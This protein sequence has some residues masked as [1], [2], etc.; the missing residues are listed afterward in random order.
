MTLVGNLP[1]SFQIVSIAGDGGSAFVT[2][3]DKGALGVMAG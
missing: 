1:F 3:F 2:S